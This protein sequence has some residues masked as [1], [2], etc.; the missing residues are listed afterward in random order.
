VQRVAYR[1]AGVRSVMLD[2]DSTYIFSRSKH[3]Q[4][5]DRTYKRGY[6]LHPLLCF[7]AASGAAVHARLCHGKA[8]PSTGIATF[9]C[10]ALRRVPDGVAVRARLDSGFYGA[11]L[12]DHMEAA[13]V[14]YLCG[15]PLSPPILQAAAAMADECWMP[16]LD[17]TKAKSPGSAIGYVTGGGS[18][19]TSSSGGPVKSSV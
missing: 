18:A 15:V 8:G 19:A 7:D 11:R 9:L 17:R 13:G 4:G 3:R 16:C 12:L 6:A 10:E 5:A 2:L 1:A 14:T